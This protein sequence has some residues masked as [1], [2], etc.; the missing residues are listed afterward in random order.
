MLR[1][2]LVLA[3][4]LVPC[5][6]AASPADAAAVRRALGAADR[7]WARAARAPAAAATAVP[8]AHAAYL[9]AYALSG[10]SSTEAYWEAVRVATVGCL[11]DAL[12]P[13]G[14]LQAALD[15]E[16]ASS[17]SAAAP[18]GVSRISHMVA[19]AHLDGPRLLRLAR[20]W[21]AAFDEEG[22]GARLP[23]PPPPPPPP[24]R[25]AWPAARRAR[26]LRGTH[27]LA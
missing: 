11:H 19:L 21:A 12:P 27:T 18:H 6:P 3:L 2:A 20:A 25:P 22:G 5:R 8:A 1:A 14:E 7:A 17:A 23:P 24:P 16:L 13:R 9:A 4:L 26:L 15:A 10:N